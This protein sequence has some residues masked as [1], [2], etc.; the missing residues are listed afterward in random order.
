MG[1]RKEMKDE[2]YFSLV[3]AAGVGMEAGTGTEP[4]VCFGVTREVGVTERVCR[5][6]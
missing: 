4:V 6:C 2:A 1:L 5:L 3:E